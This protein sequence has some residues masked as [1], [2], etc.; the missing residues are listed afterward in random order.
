MFSYIGLQEIWSIG[1]YFELPGYN[2]LEYRSRDM[3]S[4]PNPNC[5]GGAVFFLSKQF[6]VKISPGKFKIIG[7]IYKPNTGP[8]ADL[9]KAIAT[10]CSII[11]SILANK[12]HKNS[13][14]EI[15]SDFNIDLLNFEKH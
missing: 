11:S 6:K 10:H 13:S 15:I 5:G 7:N 3:R 1:E 12:K 4:N 14:I 8:R 2:K 9:K